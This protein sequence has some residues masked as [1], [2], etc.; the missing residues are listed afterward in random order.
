MIGQTLL[1]KRE[2]TNRNYEA[3][4]QGREAKEHTIKRV[5]TLGVIIK[6][7]SL[8]SGLKPPPEVY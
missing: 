2:P 6:L 4:T 8:H 5:S 3:N 1:V 7:D